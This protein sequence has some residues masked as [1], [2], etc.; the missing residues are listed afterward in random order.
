MSPTTQQAALHPRRAT[1]DPEEGDL[2]IK[3]SVGVLERRKGVPGL[4]TEKMPPSAA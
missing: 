1:L 3:S 2:G 4:K